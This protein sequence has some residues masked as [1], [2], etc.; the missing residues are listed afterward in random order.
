MQSLSCAACA[1]PLRP[2]A[3]GHGHYRMKSAAAVGAVA[4]CSRPCGAIG[5]ML[6]AIGAPPT[7]RTAGDAELADNEPKA[8]RGGCGDEQQ[9]DADYRRAEAWLRVITNIIQQLSMYPDTIIINSERLKLMAMM[10]GNSIG[11]IGNDAISMLSPIVDAIRALMRKIKDPECQAYDM[12]SVTNVVHNVVR[13]ITQLEQERSI[14]AA[15]Y[16]GSMFDTVPSDVRRMVAQYVAPVDFPLAATIKLR[17][18]SQSQFVVECCNRFIYLIAYPRDLVDNVD[19]FVY[20]YSGGYVNRFLVPFYMDAQQNF[21]EPLDVGD[22]GGLIAVTELTE[23][24]YTSFRAADDGIFE[25]NMVQTPMSSVVRYDNQTN[26]ITAVISPNEYRV[27]DVGQ[28]GISMRT[29]MLD[30]V[31]DIFDNINGDTDIMNMT[32][33]TKYGFSIPHVLTM[34]SGDD[35][36][37]FDGTGIVDLSKK[38]Y[39][40]IRPFIRG[41]KFDYLPDGSFVVIQHENR[42]QIARYRKMPEEIKMTDFRLVDPRNSVHVNIYGYRCAF[43][44]LTNVVTDILIVDLRGIPFAD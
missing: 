32:S 6:A 27:M 41:A 26:V 42:I 30:D 16:R 43:S 25:L 29:V 33:S 5:L 11:M 13:R 8:G 35:D 36:G 4:A 2:D 17:V 20:D 3:A 9:R 23:D 34:P 31:G 19:C 12:S 7:K 10:V 38:T 40:V 39:G 37:V 21:F 14:E 15:A 28:T 24:E 1:A 22:Q 18:P 44:Y